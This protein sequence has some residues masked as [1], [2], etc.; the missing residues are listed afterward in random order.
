[1][2][3][4]N[5]KMVG[6]IIGQYKITEFIA[7]GGMA[8]VYRAYDDGLDR[9]VALKILFPQYSR[10]A[11]F[12][13][14]FQREA[15]AAASLRHPNIVQVYATGTTDEGDH[16][17][18]ME[19]VPDGTLESVNRELISRGKVIET[20]RVLRV[21]RQVADAL[22]EAHANG[23]VHRDLKPSNILL[24][25]NNSPVLTDLGIAL[26]GNNPRLTQ[27]N[28]MMGTPDYMSPE[29]AEGK[30]VDGR[31]DIYSFGIMLYEL[32]CGRRP[33]GKETPWMIIHKQIHEQPKPLSVIRAG[34]VPHIYEIVDRCMA[35]TPDLR[36]QNAT[37]LVQALEESIEAL[38]A[39]AG[40]SGEWQTVTLD[41]AGVQPPTGRAE[42]TAPASSGRITPPPSNP[43]RPNLTTQTSNHR[44]SWGL[45]S[46]IALI[47]L[48]IGGLSAFLIS[49]INR[50]PIRITA[51][52]PATSEPIAVVTVEE[53]PT[54]VPAATSEPE[55]PTATPTATEAPTETPTHTPTSTPTPTA[56][57]TATATQPVILG[58]GN[59]LPIRFE[60]DDAWSVEGN[61][62]GEL[63]VS[64]VQAF[65]GEFSGQINYE[66]STDENETLTLV[67]VNPMSG[68]PDTF[69]VRVYGD[70]SGH[71]IL[72]LLL[73]ANQQTWQIPLGAI[74]HEDRWAFMSGSL[75]ANNRIA[76]TQTSDN[77]LDYPVEFYALQ[78]SD[79]T[80]STNGSGTIFVDDVSSYVAA[81]AATATPTDADETGDDDS[82]G[83]DDE[84]A[85]DT[86]AYTVSIPA[87][88]RCDDG[89]HDR[90]H[91]RRMEFK[92]NSSIAQENL[93]EG[94]KFVLIISGGNPPINEGRAVFSS[95]STIPNEW[96][97]FIEPADIGIQNNEEYQWRVELRDANDQLLASDRG[98]FNT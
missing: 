2:S 75:G 31:S 98:C 13:E 70:G 1:M 24:R 5:N 30:A 82:G 95:H 46:V 89:P 63:V 55:T 40:E 20:G 90:P 44:S 23:I 60:N 43:S 7:N 97:V 83:D 56:T 22:Q 39:S 6:R 54:E 86:A 10:D 33:F 29:Q 62:N 87:G 3:E 96:S 8:D 69:S 61:A 49:S 18:A 36:Y 19:F 14:R 51:P 26:S 80:D 38:G 4:D 74:N 25:G 21:M 93:P 17:I 53:P 85:T 64:N 68:Q 50:E 28:K 67:Q 9:D 78:L 41:A 73:D 92:W 47:V 91:D 58:R 88:L 37:E 34:L 16:Y 59:G 45:G 35:K 72:A 48:A 76:L 66:F 84:D 57:P 32:L 94:F 12:I 52:P 71:Q 79:L 42:A 11:E 15:R 27:T 77:T 65:D 81:A